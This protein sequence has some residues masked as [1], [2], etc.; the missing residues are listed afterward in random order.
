MYNL[1]P[2]IR[3]FLGFMIC[4]FIYV[5]FSRPLDES[6]AFSQATLFIS[7]G[8]LILGTVL[9]IAYQILKE[10]IYTITFIKRWLMKGKS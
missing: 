4:F 1:T 3:S 5:F 2:G 8:I 6:L 9:W 7:C 10:T